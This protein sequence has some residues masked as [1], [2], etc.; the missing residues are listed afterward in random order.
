M[1]IE[2]ARS[3]VAFLRRSAGISLCSALRLAA[4]VSLRAY[5]SSSSS[6]QMHESTNG[7]RAHRMEQLTCPFLTGAM[8]DA[9]QPRGGNPVIILPRP[10]EVDQLA[11]QS[12]GFGARCELRV[13]CAQSVLV[14][15]YTCCRADVQCD[16][17]CHKN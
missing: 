11:S 17:P 9:W 6:R 8:P 5:R 13:L 16:P 15:L 14:V 2:T 4:S 12:V 10:R 7:Y 1:G 3:S